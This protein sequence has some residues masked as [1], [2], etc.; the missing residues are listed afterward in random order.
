[1]ANTQLCDG[2]SNC[3]NGE[4]ELP[5]KCPNCHE[6]GDFKCATNNRCIPLSLRCNQ[7]DDCGDG[8][9]ENVTMCA[10]V[11]QRACSE[12]EFRCANGRCVRGT[13]R[14]DH[15]NDCGDNS[16]EQSCESHDCG[17]NAWKCTSGHC[18]AAR[19]RCDGIRNCLDF[20]DET[21][22]CPPRYPN[23]KYCLGEDV[24][25]TCNNTFCISQSYRCDGDNDCGD[26]SDETLSLCGGFNCTKE[27][28]R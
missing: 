4:D 20:S 10:Q 3:P 5:S 17:A 24:H 26:G 18:I 13:W 23:G 7:M 28:N 9:D 11:G 25:Y 21:Q 15:D 19:Q 12:S 22:Q 6:T 27:N 8:S 2:Y 16:D 1:V 14:C